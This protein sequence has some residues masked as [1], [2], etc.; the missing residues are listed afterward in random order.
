MKEIKPEELQDNPFKLIGKDWLL[1]TAEKDD[2]VNMMT[3]SWGQVG[4]MWNK[5]V[6]NIFI[7]S[8]RF[9]KT[10]ID[11]SDTFTL[12]VLPEEF[13]SAMNL[14]GSKSGRDTDK[15]KETGLTVEHDGAL[16]YFKESRLVIECRKLYSQVMP[17]SAF[18][19][20]DIYKT[21][22]ANNDLHTQYICEIT[23]IL[24]K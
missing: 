16:P 23:K 9:T 4:I 14:C 10:F 5:P 17:E 24:S 22:Y 21:A 15:V 19:V 8:S 20:K 1:I 3:A 7:R 18:D 6:V 11:S 12:C 13:R 2:R